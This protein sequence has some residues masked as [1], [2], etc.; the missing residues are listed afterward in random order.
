MVNLSQGIAF[1]MGNNKQIKNLRTQVLDQI[2]TATTYNSFVPTE[3]SDI[4]TA[5]SSQWVFVAL[6]TANNVKGFIVSS[7]ERSISSQTAPSFPTQHILSDVFQTSHLCVLNVTSSAQRLSEGRPLEAPDAIRRFC[8]SVKN[9]ISITTKCSAMPW[10]GHASCV[11][12]SVYGI[13]FFHIPNVDTRYKD[14]VKYR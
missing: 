9:C 5:C 3:V 2:Y 6:P 4:Q 13:L 12:Y 14:A 11:Y 8:S 1:C 7:L 10:K